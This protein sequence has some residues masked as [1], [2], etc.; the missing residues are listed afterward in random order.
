LQEVLKVLAQHGPFA[1]IS[2]GLIYLFVIV[3]KRFN[4]FFQQQHDALLEDTK[5]KAKLTEALEDVAAS[6][7]TL[8]VQVNEYIQDRKMEQAKEEG[9]R[10]VTGRFKIPPGGEE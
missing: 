7:E 1:I 10:E 8:G 2:G 5:T 6:V 9:R 4:E 3:W